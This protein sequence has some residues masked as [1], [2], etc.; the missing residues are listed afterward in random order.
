MSN[1]VDRIEQEIKLKG[2]TFNRVEHDCGFGG[3][4]IKRWMRQSPRFDKLVTVAQYLEVSLDYLAFGTTHL[5]NHPNGEIRFDLSLSE[6]ESDLIQKIRLL[7][8][9]QQ[10]E[11]F[12][13]VDFKC[14]CNTERKKELSYTNSQL[15]ASKDE[16]A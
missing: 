8:D 10:E 13:L 12:D 15:K 1:L 6:K 11:L 9:Y 3:G 5:E 16:T 7:P 2:L 4:T 14:H